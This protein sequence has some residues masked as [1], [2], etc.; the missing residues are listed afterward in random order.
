MRTLVSCKSSQQMERT[1]K[2]VSTECTQHQ[3]LVD[4]EQ[5]KMHGKDIVTSCY[6]IPDTRL[7]ETQTDH[8]QF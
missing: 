5:M 6:N 1:S 3:E 4:Y 8:F 2:A 7:F